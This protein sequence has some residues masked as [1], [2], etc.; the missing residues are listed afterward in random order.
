MS[1]QLSDEEISE[2]Q[3]QTGFTRSQI[4]R[5]HNRY[6]S[7]AKS[8]EG[9]KVTREDLLRIPEIHINP[10]GDRIVDAF[11]PAHDERSMLTASINFRQFVET[12]ARFRPVKANTVENDINSREAKLDFAFRMYDV[13]GDHF[14]TRDE[15]LSLLSMMVGSNITPEQLA[16]IADRTILEAD[17]DEDGKI[18][19]DEFKKI[20]AKVD[21]EQR[22]SIRFLT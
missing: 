8:D 4:I 12:L 6:L 5:L 15:L 7:L 17:K 16:S 13:N 14:I 11:F 18:S 20:M 19:F 21:V 10:L 3:E 2:L 1:S 22:M 9:Q